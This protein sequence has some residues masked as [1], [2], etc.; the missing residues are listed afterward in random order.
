MHYL[1][2]LYANDFQKIFIFLSYSW[3]CGAG[4]SFMDYIEKLGEELQSYS[5][6]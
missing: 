3:N 2:K 4:A 1:M 6:E 5:E